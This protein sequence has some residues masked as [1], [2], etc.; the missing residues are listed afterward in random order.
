MLADADQVSDEPLAVD[1]FVPGKRRSDLGSEALTA[2]SVETGPGHSEPTRNVPKRAGPE[3]GAVDLV[4][5]LVTANRAGPGHAFNLPDGSD[6]NSGR[7]QTR[8]VR[9]PD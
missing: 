2:V 9:Q 6:G 3:Q 4:F 7:L 1:L 8:S 5:G